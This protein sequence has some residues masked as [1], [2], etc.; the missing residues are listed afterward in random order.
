MKKP[1]ITAVIAVLLLTASVLFATA[2]LFG[3]NY[4][5]TH[6]GEYHII[7]IVEFARMLGEG[8]MVPRWAPDMN[9]GYGIPIFQ[10]HYPLP[11]YI[12]SL[13]RVFTRDAVYAFQYSVGIGYI[14][15]IAAL[16]GWLFTLFG[17]IPA[18]VGAI[19]GAYVPY[20]F[21]DIYIRGVIGE[22]WATAMLFAVLFFIEKRKYVFVA[23]WYCLLILS[24]NILAMVY[25]PFLLGYVLI[26][27]KAAL[28][29][30]LAGVGLSAFFWLPALAEST[31]VVGLNTVNFRGHFVEIS[32]LLVPSWG[33]GFSEAGAIGNKMSFQIGL[34]PLVVIALAVLFYRKSKNPPINTLLRYFLIVCVCSLLLM[35]SPF[36]FVWEIV[37]PL[38]Y[39]QYPWRLLIFVIPVAAYAASFIVKNVKKRWV[40]IILP[41]MAILCAYSYVHPV[42]YEPRNEAYYLARPNFTDG[43]SS[44]GNSFSTIWT[45]WKENRP[46]SEVDI[47]D[48]QFGRRVRWKYLDRDFSVFM[49]TGGDITISTLYFP[50]WNAYVDGA[51]VVVNYGEDG[52]I[53]FFVP[54]GAHNVHV[55]FKD[56]LP[57]QAGNII[58][59]ISL[60][61]VGYWFILAVTQKKQITDSR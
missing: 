45:K 7:R 29:S 19:V 9:S 51:R 1:I 10:Y 16:F 39:V 42:L 11:N 44:M 30:I 60:V 28:K 14:V 22:V 47:P 57:R 50:G 32:E 56:T 37:W 26:R 6:D 33:T 17:I 54:E 40:A 55:I 48:G 13:V 36:R 27:D 8:N 59:L 41:V 12:G 15:A 4:I 61:I 38:Q 23:L 34:V 24:H 3:K 18:A 46:Q 35:F 31:Y 5:P 20:W 52:V 43:T 58:S 53:H 49:N 21:V 25:T 2:S